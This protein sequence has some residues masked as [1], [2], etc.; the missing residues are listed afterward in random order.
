LVDG[1]D[2]GAVG[3]LRSLDVDLRSVRTAMDD[4]GTNS[5]DS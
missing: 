2:G 1:E 5:R 4:T 3:V